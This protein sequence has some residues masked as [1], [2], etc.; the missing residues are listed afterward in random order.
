MTEDKKARVKAFQI[1]VKAMSEEERLAMVQRYCAIITVNAHPLT[2]KNTCLVL[3]QN[4]K[5]T[6][7]GGF[8]QWLAA[9]RC[10]RK[11][12]KSISICYPC[13]SKKVNAEGEEEESQ[14]FNFGNVFDISQTDEI[15]PTESTEAAYEDKD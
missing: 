4:P 14:Y 12:E 2:I 5:S 9:G 6:I 7:V 10:V 11:G 15:V 13:R 3:F 8:K 1:R